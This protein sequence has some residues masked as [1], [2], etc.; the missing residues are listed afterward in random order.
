LIDRRGSR[1]VDE[2]RHERRR[3]TGTVVSTWFT[4]EVDVYKK[5]SET[6]GQSHDDTDLFSLYKCW[7]FSLGGKHVDYSSQ[8]PGGGVFIQLTT[9]QLLLKGVGLTH[10]SMK[11]ND[12]S[13]R[14]S[15]SSREISTIFQYR[16]GLNPCSH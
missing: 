14:K 12:H 3:S 16:T 7:W 13:F 8:G 5:G 9:T 11:W 10:S 2:L 1:D 15:S 4:K 6:A